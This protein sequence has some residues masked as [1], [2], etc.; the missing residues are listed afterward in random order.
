M[1]TIWNTF[2]YDTVATYQ[3]PFHYK[4]IDHIII[5]RARKR[6]RYVAT[7]GRLMQYG[8]FGY[9]VV[10]IVNTI[11]FKQPLTTTQNLTNLGIATA[12]GVAGTV[13]KSNYGNPYRKTH[14]YRVVYVNMQ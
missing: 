4:E 9:D 2:F 14:K 1:Q 13:L 10:N 8:G 3:V 12:V 11:Y 5:P 7:L 6:K